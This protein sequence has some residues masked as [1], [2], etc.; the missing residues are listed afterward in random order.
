MRHKC[1]VL[2]IQDLS[3]DLKVVAVV[4]QVHEI[5]IVIINGGVSYE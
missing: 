2:A 3:G 4:L 5:D 1:F